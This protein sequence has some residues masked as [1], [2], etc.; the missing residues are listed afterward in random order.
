MGVVYSQLLFLVSSRD[1]AKGR[2]SRLQAEISEEVQR[3]EDLTT[4][5]EEF[6]QVDLRFS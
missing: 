5:M 3:L 6:H 4:A 1:V 2:I